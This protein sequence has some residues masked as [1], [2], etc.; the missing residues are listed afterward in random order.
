MSKEIT[1]LQT[2]ALWWL[3]VRGGAGL[4]KDMNFTFT[5]KD[6]EALVAAGLITADT[7][8]RPY[9]LQVT[10]KGWHWAGTAATDCVITRSPA[11]AGVLQALLACLGTYMQA[12]D[13]ALAE[14]LSP[15]LPSHASEAQPTASPIATMT[16]PADLRDRI[17]STFLKLTGG[18]LNTS[19]PLRELR[20]E[21]K[22]IDRSML[23]EALLA[24]EREDDRATLM[25][26]DNQIE[27]TDED[28]KAALRVGVEPRHL[29]WISR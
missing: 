23:D 3:L 4:Q 9:I 21:I 24:I 25:Q 16:E 28:R 27:I 10:D 29:L 1:P 7:R 22:D 12:R 17:R 20:A 18:K 2:L 5:P 6:R 13:I 19:V 11:V 14:I 8:K 15:T 26:I